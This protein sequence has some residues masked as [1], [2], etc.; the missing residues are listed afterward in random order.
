VPAE[1]RR[2][3]CSPYV[4]H[5]AAEEFGIFRDVAYLK[6]KKREAI[7]KRSE[8]FK[9]TL[10]G[11]FLFRETPVVLVVNVSTTFHGDTPSG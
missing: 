11:Q 6:L 4:S 3:S 9:E 10:L 1:S 7:L 8:L 5:E 2:A